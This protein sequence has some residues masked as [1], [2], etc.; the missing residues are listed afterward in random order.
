MHTIRETA[1]VSSAYVIAEIL[2][3]FVV[4]GM[5]LIKIDSLEESLFFTALVTF[6]LIYMLFLIK[7]L[8]D[9]FDYRE[10]GAAGAEVS[11]KP[12]EDLIA[13]MK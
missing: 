5:V 3:F 2:A 4:S 9:P 11:L 13:R 12:L 10:G 8:D 1:F 7:D 6:L